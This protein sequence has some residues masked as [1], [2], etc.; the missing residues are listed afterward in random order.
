M[1]CS[2]LSESS[3]SLYMRHDSRKSD[4]Q[5]HPETYLVRQLDLQRRCGKGRSSREVPLNVDVRKALQAW[6]D[7]RAAT[8]SR[9]LFIGQRGER[10][11]PS[12]I[13]RLVKKYAELA[14][15]PDLRVHDLRH[16]VLT[17]LV[18]EFGMDP[19]AVAKI[20]GHRNLQTLMRY[21]QANADDLANAVEKLAFTGE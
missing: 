17:R 7:V 8:T 12:G 18:R 5:D 15:V 20:S 11:T 14:G 2:S 6:L 10:M 19:V 1:K 9:F 16:T 13:W 21:A 4:P 3:L